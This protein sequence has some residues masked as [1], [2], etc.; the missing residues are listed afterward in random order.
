MAI[1]GIALRRNEIKKPTNI[2]M[3]TL[4]AN[5]SINFFVMWSVMTVSNCTNDNKKLLFFK[6]E[7]N[8]RQYI[9]ETMYVQI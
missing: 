6:Y 5:H 1:C 3:P 4:S 8:I 9:Y 2:F 7:E